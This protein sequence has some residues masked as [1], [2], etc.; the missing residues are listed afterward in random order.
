MKKR[1][2]KLRGILKSVMVRMVQMKVEYLGGLRCRTWHGPS[3]DSFLT[4]APVDNMGK[5]EAFSPTDLT[6]VALGACV[7]TTMAIVAERHQV[8]LKGMTVEVEKEMS[9]DSPRRIRRI[10]VALDIPLPGSHELRERLE[11]AAHACPV[12]Q[13]LH[14]D[15]VKDIRFAWNG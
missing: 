8:E 11:R 1:E 2:S 6:A 5:G 12:H 4:D 3:G 7:A 9:T 10:G 15:V 14:P 13:S